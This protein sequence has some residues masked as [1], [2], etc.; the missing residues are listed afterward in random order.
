MPSVV[1][2]AAFSSCN[3]NDGNDDDDDGDD[4]DEVCLLCME[5]ISG[6]NGTCRC[7]NLAEHTMMFPG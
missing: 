2:S 1:G 7:P 4:E 6:R 3:D 5:L